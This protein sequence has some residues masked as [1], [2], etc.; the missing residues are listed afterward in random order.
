MLTFDADSRMTARRIADLI[1]KME[2]RPDLGL[3]QSGVRLTGAQTRFGRVQQAATRLY[4][5]AFT[6]GIAGWSGDAGN[7]WGHNALARVVAFAEA[8]G[9]P[10][11]DGRPPFGGDV[12]S[13]DFVEAAWLRRAGWAVEIDPEAW[14]STEEG[15]Q[16]LAEFHKRDRRWCQGNLQHVRI[17]TGARGLDPVSR[18]HLVCG[19][20]GYLASPLWLALV[21]AATL[22]GSTG[23]ILVPVLG[24]IGLLMAQKLAGVAYW[25]RGNPGAWRRVCSAAAGETLVS[26]LLAPIVMMRQTVAVAVGA[27]RAGLRLEAGGAI[28]PARRRRRHAVARTGCRCRTSA[29][30]AA[31]R[32]RP[33]AGRRRVADRA[34]ADGGTLA[35]RLARRASAGGA[36]GCPAACGRGAQA[37]QR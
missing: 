30:G 32:G 22:S 29:G 36:P 27:E 18:L 10:R 12:L 23:T 19:I 37:L 33:L 25:L 21:V 35:C 28:R 8:A 5:P 13:H 7:Y 14:G 4:G 26:S 16:T 3:I 11:L 24:A 31:R 34:A 15:P 9:L 17:L 6:A 20:F 2:A 1:R